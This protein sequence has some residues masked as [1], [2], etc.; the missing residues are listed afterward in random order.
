MRILHAQ[1]R[2]GILGLL[3]VCG[4]TVMPN[5]ISA[6]DH[7]IIVSDSVGPL[8]GSFE[9]P[10]DLYTLSTGVPGLQFA[11]EVDAT[12]VHC[13]GWREGAALTAYLAAVGDP[14]T[15]DVFVYPS[16]FGLWAWWNFY[17]P[18][19]A[20]E[21]GNEW[22]IAEFEVVTEVEQTVE[23]ELNLFD[24]E[25]SQWLSSTFA[26]ISIEDFGPP[27]LRSDVN[28]NFA[29]NLVDA[30]DLLRHLFLGEFLECAKAGDIDDNGM[31]SLADPV[32]LLTGLFGGGS[33]P[34]PVCHPDVTP[35]PIECLQ[36]PCTT[37]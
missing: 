17:I 21:F 18:F 26:T 15:C 32:N 24:S 25:S 36:Y 3:A 4:I 27:I 10:L 1:I 33:L 12:V 34:L 2:L 35:D 28:G 13:V 31:L 22:I 19:S 30:V 29:V 37:P 16:G 20:N 5:P 7:Q 23:I 9:I 8:H 14:E 6:Q 11:L